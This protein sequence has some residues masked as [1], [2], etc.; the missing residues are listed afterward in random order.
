M[1]NCY[2]L[3]FD[4]HEPSGSSFENRLEVIR[5]RSSSNL[6]ARDMDSL[7]D[8]AEEDGGPRMAGERRV[9]LLGR[10]EPLG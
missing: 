10:P 6:S 7:D 4:V 5:R 9:S 3:E 2:Y 1:S 8:V